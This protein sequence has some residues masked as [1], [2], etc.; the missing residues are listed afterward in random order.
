MHTNYAA[1]RGAA[2]ASEYPKVACEKKKKKSVKE[3]VMKAVGSGVSVLS[4]VQG[5]TMSFVTTLSC[6]DANPVLCTLVTSLP[7]PE[8]G[9]LGLENS[10]GRPLT[11]A[12]KCCITDAL[13]GLYN[14]TFLIDD[15]E[16]MGRCTHP[17]PRITSLPNASMEY[18][19]N[20]NCGQ[21]NAFVLL[22]VTSTGK[23]H[24][25]FWSQSPLVFRV[26]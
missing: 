13:S 11:H 8:A 21:P 22:Y 16:T 24:T 12:M 14:G 3:L 25:S 10:A 7:S 18:T 26:I 6:T 1:T 2:D 19:L 15:P 20:T 9:N 5:L 17:Y 23:F 4:N